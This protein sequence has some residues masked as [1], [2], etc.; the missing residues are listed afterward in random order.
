MRRFSIGRV[1]MVGNTG[2]YLD[3]PYHRYR[4]GYDLSGLPLSSSSTPPGLVIRV[5]G[6]PGRA[7]DWKAF[8]AS[9]VV[10]RAVLVHTGWDEHWAT[11]TAK[12]TRS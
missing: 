10:G 3:T 7:I 11:V 8:A 6:A 1:E 9:D 5:T 2:T 12:V 4:E